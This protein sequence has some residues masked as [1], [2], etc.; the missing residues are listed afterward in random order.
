MMRMPL[1]G[2]GKDRGRYRENQSHP[3]HPRSINSYVEQVV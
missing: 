2:A 3:R 1:I